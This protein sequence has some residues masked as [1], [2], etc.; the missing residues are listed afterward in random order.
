[1][2]PASPFTAHPLGPLA[3]VGGFQHGLQVRIMVALF[4]FRV[5]VVVKRNAGTNMI[6]VPEFAMVCPTHVAGELLL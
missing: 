4:D 2:V 6:D 1:M 3:E 5:N